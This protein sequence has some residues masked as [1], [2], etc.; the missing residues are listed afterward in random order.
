M[1]SKKLRYGGTA[2]TFTVAFIAL[3]IVVNVIFTALANKYRWYIDMT[4]TELFSLSDA[5][6]DVLRDVKDDVL[7]TFCQPKDKLDENAA[8]FYIH[9]TAQNL[10]DKFDNIK[11][12][13]KD[14]LRDNKYLEKFRTA[15]NDFVKTT[16]VI[17]SSGTEYRKY[18][19][20]KFFITDTNDTSNIWAY[21]GENKFAAAILQVTADEMP[22]AYFTK[23]HGEDLTDDATAFINLI[24]E[25][26]FEVA[27]IDLSTEEID[28]AGRLLIINN[29]KADF[30]GA[31]DQHVGKSEIEKI[32]DFLDNLGSVMAFV[33]PENVGKL[34]NL[35]EFLEEW[36]VIFNPGVTV[37]DPENAISVDGFSVV[38][39]YNTT[40]GEL[41]ASIYTS[42]T[43]MSSQPKA[44]FRNASPITHAWE[45]ESKTTPDLGSRVISDVFLTS[46]TAKLNENGTA[47]DAT[48]TY[49]LMT[50]TQ[51]YKIIDN[52][53]YTSYVIAAGTPSFTASEFLLSNIYTN[54]DVIHSCLIAL[55]KENVPAGIDFKVFADYDLDITTAQAANWTRAF[56]I[57]MPLATVIACI[58]V[59]VRR[60]YK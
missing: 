39:Q 19:S 51:E 2:V 17:I 12:E 16:S 14:A 50:I 34:D 43:S 54:R 38:G 60:K 25:A 26:G 27:A 5:T 53:D 31:F 10:A 47:T 28:P 13:Y 41:A 4:S 33:S 18:D 7:I 20:T 1:R 44:I 29:P 32:D 52:E 56:I 36:G 40:E 24:E 30:G 35:S 9:N 46:P 3:V 21:D 15:S 45:T 48:G 57:V 6:V 59:T 42:I 49:S 11:I 37:S 23:G 8:M 55:G 22:I 58:V